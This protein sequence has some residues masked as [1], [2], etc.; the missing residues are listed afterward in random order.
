MDYLQQN[1]S[2]ASRRGPAR[3]R[4][5]CGGRRTIRCTASRRARSL[6]LSFLEDLDFGDE[7]GLVG[8]GEWASR[9]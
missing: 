8:Y 4:K 6:F 1:R 7:V 2:A 3:L 9:R 5:T